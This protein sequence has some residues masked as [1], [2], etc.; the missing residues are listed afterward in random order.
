[1]SASYFFH[2]FAIIMHTNTR[3]NA[4]LINIVATVMNFCNGSG[5]NSVIPKGTFTIYLLPPFLSLSFS[6]VQLQPQRRY[7]LQCSKHI[8][9]REHTTAYKSGKKNKKNGGEKTERKEG[10]GEGAVAYWFPHKSPPQCI[11]VNL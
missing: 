8:L 4:T 2:C 10:K 1:M 3:A 11:R 5:N 9:P 7:S 6:H